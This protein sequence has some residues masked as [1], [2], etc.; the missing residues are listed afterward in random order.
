MSRTIPTDIKYAWSLLIDID[1]LSDTEP[2]KEIL[3]TLESVVKFVPTK[4][5]LVTGTVSLSEPNLRKTNNSDGIQVE[6]ETITLMEVT[7]FTNVA[8]IIVG[9]N[10]TH[11]EFKDGK[12]A[13]IILP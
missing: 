9:R 8:T 5:L 6:L 13:N 1:S 12:F 7:D 10:T 2:I 11:I 4:S 3:S